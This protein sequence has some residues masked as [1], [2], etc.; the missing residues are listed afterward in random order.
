MEFETQ[1][2][3]DGKD[4]VQEFLLDLEDHKE[5]EY[6]TAFK[7]TEKLSSFQQ[8]TFGELIRAEHR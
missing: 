7:I 2:M 8:L 4:P 3:P 6:S 1:K 5:E